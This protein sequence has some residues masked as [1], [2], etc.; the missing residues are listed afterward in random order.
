MAHLLLLHDGVSAQRWKV[1]HR[2]HC[3]CHQVHHHYDHH[4]VRWGGPKCDGSHMSLEPRALPPCQKQ[5]KLVLSSGFQ[6]FIDKYSSQ[7]VPEQNNSFATPTLCL[8]PMII[9]SSRLQMNSSRSLTLY[10][11]GAEGRCADGIQ[12]VATG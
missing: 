2:H 11:G 5:W 8:N 1:Q 7:C 6:F 3:R 4:Q 12:Y 9:H 10:L